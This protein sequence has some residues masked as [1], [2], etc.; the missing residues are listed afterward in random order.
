MESK[1]LKILEIHSLSNEQFNREKED[2]DLNENALYLTP[3]EEIV[4]EIN[5]SSKNSQIPTAKAVYEFVMKA[6]N[7]GV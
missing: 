2:G 5:E 7:G 1:N 6:L 4:E 3:D